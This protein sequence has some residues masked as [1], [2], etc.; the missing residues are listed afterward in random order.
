MG[1]RGV[2]RGRGGQRRQDLHCGFEL[3]ALVLLQGEHHQEQGQDLGLLVTHQDLGQAVNPVLDGSP[4]ALLD[5]SL[6]LQARVWSI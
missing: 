5:V 3:D 2:V 4:H 1:S 6:Q